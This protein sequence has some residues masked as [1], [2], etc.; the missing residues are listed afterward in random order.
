MNVANKSLPCETLNQLRN[1]LVVLAKSNITDFEHCYYFAPDAVLSVQLDKRPSG[2]F[3]VQ[4]KSPF[5]EE[6][7]VQS[8]HKNMIP[9]VVGFCWKAVCKIIAKNN[10]EPCASTEHGGADEILALHRSIKAF[11]EQEN[12]S[13]FSS[14]DIYPRENYELMNLQ[15]ENG[16]GTM[17]IMTKHVH[18]N[19]IKSII[20]VQGADQV[21]V[22]GK[23][24]LED[25]LGSWLRPSTVKSYRSPVSAANRQ[26]PSQSQLSDHIIF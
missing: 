2:E 20:P 14:V 6:T 21:S 19:L 22:R 25:L 11:D 23:S 26:P 18:G 1:D 15:L 16:R 24:L 10:L 12:K 4:I 5:G 7:V 3:H 8:N 17:T 9:I 13:V